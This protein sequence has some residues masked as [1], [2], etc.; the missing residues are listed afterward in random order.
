MDLKYLITFRTIIEEDGFNKAAERLNYTQSTITFQIDQLER[1][2]STKLFERIGRK[3]VLTKSGKHLIPY[4]DE[5][6]SSVNKLCNFE[7]ELRDFKGDLYIGVAETLL[8]W[9]M[10]SILRKVN[11]KAPNA[12]L[13]IKSMNCYDIR[14]ELIRGN[15]DIGVFYEDVNRLGSNIITYPL[16]IY[17]LVLVSSPKLKKQY[18]DFITPDRN[19]PITFIIK[20]PNCMFRRIFENYLRQKSIII[21]HVIELWSI[22]T[23]KNLV[24]NDVGISYLPKFSV[25]DDLKKGSLVEI[26]TELN[27][28][29]I[30][31]VCAHHKNKCLTPLM[32]LFIDL[33]NDYFNNIQK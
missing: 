6:L 23:I 11:K 31:A 21:D 3:M 12:R 27:N 4:V 13:F 9:Y 32:K 29:T 24:K 26:E 7:K 5:V 15:L 16:G 18:P 28:T 20:E 19:M 10:P 2:L 8:C 30:S 22:P 14:D 1:E 17:E 33:C 25:E